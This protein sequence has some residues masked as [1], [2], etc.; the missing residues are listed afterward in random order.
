MYFPYGRRTDALRKKKESW[1][2]R[3]PVVLGVE[4]LEARF[5]ADAHVVPFA[6]RAL[7][8]VLD[9]MGA[10]GLDELLARTAVIGDVSAL[11][12]EILPLLTERG[13]VDEIVV[14][15]GRKGIPAWAGYAG[16]GKKRKKKPNTKN[17]NLSHDPVRDPYLHR[18][19]SNSESVFKSL[20][21]YARM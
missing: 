6:I 14:G 5:G 21:L 2:R 13:D 3:L 16:D 15:H 9:R 17:Y 4:L 7:V 20:I 1:K 12:I 8:P 11:G 10:D 18:F 19:R